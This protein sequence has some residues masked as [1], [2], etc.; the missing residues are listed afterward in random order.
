MSV[1]HKAEQ[2]P[3]IEC[4]MA[5]RNVGAVAPI[6]G[7]RALP[8]VETQAGVSRTPAMRLDEDLLSGLMTSIPDNIYFKDRQSRF[9]RINEAMARWFGL[10]DPADAVGKTD[11][12]FFGQE[13][14]RQAFADEQRIMA[15]DEALEGAEEKETWPDGRVTWVSTTKV[16]VRDAGGAVVGLLGISRD[17][18]ER[19]K[20]EEQLLAS[21]KMEAV[22]RLAGGVAH[23]FNNLLAVIVGYGEMVLK[24]LEKGSPLHAKQLEVLKAAQRAASL[25]GQLLAFS[26]KQVLQPRVLDVNDVVS[27][28][29]ALLRRLI[30]EDIELRTHSAPDLGSVSADPGQLGQIIMNLAVNAR[31]AMPRGGRLTIETASVELDATYA[32]Q[33]PPTTPGR[34]VMLAVSDSGCGM[35][36]EVRAHIF[37]PF[38]TTKA[39]GEGTGLGLSTVYGI[40]KQSG[41]CVWVYS[42]PG[43]GTTFKIYLPR[44]DAAPCPAPEIPPVAPGC[45]E[46]V[47]LIEDE[48]ALR[49][50]I[51][52]M[53]ETHG[54]SVLA[55]P[56]GA[57]ALQIADE[58][59]GSIDLLIT[60][61]VMPGMSGREAAEA[62]T[63]IRPSV[64]V[65]YISGYTGD[66]IRLNGGLRRGAA[67]LS[68]PFT[69]A[70]LLGRCRGVLDGEVGA[71]ALEPDGDSGLGRLG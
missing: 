38:F 14:A 29:D 20:L 52:D 26:R 25:T 19:K 50:A 45:A 43:L 9:V 60:D 2:M 10:G 69:S 30:G 12:D 17:I 55:A 27:D 49:G 59:E 67:F 22:G 23:D 8:G 40:V 57:A 6:D 16:P 71:E 53:L 51:Q 11:A 5:E 4:T 42:E 54:Y 31:D 70:A 7:E 62:I 46:T 61:V 44:V 47:L 65:L 37:E 21:Q 68:K 35:A 28:M 39:Q 56:D 1:A 3:C 24:R 13:H 41:G 58:H 18:T 63:A 64:R 48:P 32:M 34:Y 66:A 33:H 36:P 15:T